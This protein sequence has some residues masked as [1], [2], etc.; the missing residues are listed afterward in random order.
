M[1]EEQSEETAQKQSVDDSKL[2]VEPIFVD[3]DGPE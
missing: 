2:G 3:W 1:K